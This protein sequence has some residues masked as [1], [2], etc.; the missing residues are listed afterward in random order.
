MTSLLCQS[1]CINCISVYSK[2]L[3]AYFKKNKNAEI[4][5]EQGKESIICHDL[6]EDQRLTS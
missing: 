2:L 1:E 4:N 3:R 6:C 5:D